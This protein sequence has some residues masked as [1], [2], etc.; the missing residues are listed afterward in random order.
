MVVVI[1]NGVTKSIEIDLE[2]NRVVAEPDHLKLI[3]LNF[4]MFMKSV[5]GGSNIQV[6]S[7]AFLVFE[8]KV[9]EV[10]HLRREQSAIVSSGEGPPA[11]AAPGE[12]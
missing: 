6:A 8:E 10:L 2:R 1:E 9:G 5:E 7:T 3:E 12:V 11:L 4:A